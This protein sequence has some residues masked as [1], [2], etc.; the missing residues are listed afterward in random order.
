MSKKLNEHRGKPGR[1]K[2]VIKHLEDN[3]AALTQK[4]KDV[5]AALKNNQYEEAGK[6][7]SQMYAFAYFWDAP[8][9]L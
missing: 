1:W 5:V 2:V 7:L 4:G 9:S 6:K 8:A 3:M